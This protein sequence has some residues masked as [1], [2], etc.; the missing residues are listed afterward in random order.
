MVNLLPALPLD[1]GRALRAA[2][3][4]RVGYARAT[5]LFTRAGV[6]LGALTTALGVWAALRGTLNVTLFL[7]GVYL[8]YAALKERETLAAACVE[9]LHGRAARLRREGALP[10]RVTAVGGD[11]HPE[12]LAARLT[13]GAY[14]LF[15]V[16]DDDLRR[17]ATLD[18]SEVLR[19]VFVTRMENREEK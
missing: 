5:R 18:E 8:V 19:R 7:L 10:V 3:S 14:H 13:A 15:V 9:A 12:R 4:G 17:T 2:L 1:G 16:V 6:A 11:A